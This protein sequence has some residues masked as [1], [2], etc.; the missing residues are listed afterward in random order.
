MLDLSA[1]E[2]AKSS[3]PNPNLPQ[4]TRLTDV[5]PLKDARIPTTVYEILEIKEHHEEGR[6]RNIH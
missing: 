1:G 6:A 5:I 2:I 4:R 3:V